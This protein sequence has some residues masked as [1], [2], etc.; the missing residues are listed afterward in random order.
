MTWKDRE[1]MLSGNTALMP[2]S[3]AEGAGERN[4]HR[5]LQRQYEVDAA[6]ADV[7]MK[8]L[9]DEARVE[10]IARCLLPCLSGLL[11]TLRFVV[12]AA[13]TAIVSN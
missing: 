7:A 11:P 13:H 2:D 5:V 4:P 1:G 6:L 8:L 9:T 3:S 12:A 10:P